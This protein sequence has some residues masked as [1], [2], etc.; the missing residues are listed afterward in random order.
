[1]G[2]GGARHETLCVTRSQ[3]RAQGEQSCDGFRIGSVRRCQGSSPAPHPA[4]YPHPRSWEG[5]QPSAGVSPAPAHFMVLGAAGAERRKRGGGGGRLLGSHTGTQQ[6]P[7]GP[8]CPTPL[9]AAP[10]HV[11]IILP[12]E[13][14]AP[15]RE[16]LKQINTRGELKAR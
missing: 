7:V 14:T 16:V 8:R 1:M 4:R 12:G 2:A 15:G 13:E 10:M 9:K 6:S 3:Q 5:Q 11:K